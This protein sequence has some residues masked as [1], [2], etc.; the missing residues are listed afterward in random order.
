MAAAHNNMEREVICSPLERKSL[1]AGLCE[2]VSR[3]HPGRMKS[4]SRRAKD[5]VKNAAEGFQSR[6][7]AYH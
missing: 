2:T 5:F 6:I 1:M 3:R 4:G 7:K